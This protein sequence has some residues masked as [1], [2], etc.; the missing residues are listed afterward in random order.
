MYQLI[1]RRPHHWIDTHIHLAGWWYTYPSEK[2]KFVSWD[3][4]SQ[5]MKKYN[6]CSNPP[7]RPVCGW[8]N[9]GSS[10]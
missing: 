4:Y 9:L 10:M 5:Y 6:S 1:T 7:T 2:Y 8:E 3:H